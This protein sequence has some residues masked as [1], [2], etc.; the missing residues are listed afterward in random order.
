M[1]NLAAAPIWQR[2]DID[3]RPGQN[4]THDARIL[5]QPRPQEGALALG[6]LYLRH[7]RMGREP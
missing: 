5:L 3:G 7:P 6:L 1:R 2:L 4:R